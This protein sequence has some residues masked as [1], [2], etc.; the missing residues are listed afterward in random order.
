MNQNIAN[1][2]IHTDN[3]IVPVTVGT[4]A[5]VYELV[6]WLL[7]IIPGAIFQ[8]CK[9]SAE[10]H[11]HSLEQKI[12]HHAAQID[13]YLEQ[14]V[15]V[16]KNC[17]RLLDRAID[18]DQSTFER[19]AK[20]RSGAAL[21]DEERNQLAGDL[22][23]FTRSINATVE[24]YPNLRAHEEIQ[25]AMYQ[26]MYLQKEITAARDLYNDAVFAWNRD[27]F[28]W[29]TKRIVAAKNHYTTK[30]FFETRYVEPEDTFF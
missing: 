2:T 21:T 15:I 30:L 6:L 9:I 1:T 26:N 24:N 4:G 19:L 27:I 10:N 25:E 5:K 7:F 20:Y 11:F 23:V 8:L 22:E 16:L 29:I 28:Q 13:N 3:K 14:R 17:A 12:R 18:L